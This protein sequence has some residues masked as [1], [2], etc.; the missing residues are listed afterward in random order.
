P[1]ESTAIHLIH[2]TLVHFVRYFPDS[3]F[4]TV[5]EDAFNKKINLD[6]QE[7]RDFIIL[8][9]CTSQRN[10]TDFWRWCQTMPVPDSLRE[11]LTAFRERGQ[12]EHVPGQFFTTDSWC[13]I[14]EGM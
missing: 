8:H 13:S 2:K 7:V 3:D 11:K 14:L 6:Y 12:I 9:Y 10:D 4:S 1:L 5:T